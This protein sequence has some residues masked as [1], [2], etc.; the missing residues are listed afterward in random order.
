MKKNLAA[1]AFLITVL[2]LF[3][4]MLLTIP[5]SA[6]EKD[7]IVYAVINGEVRISGSSPTLSGE[8]VIPEQI[9]GYPVTSIGPSA[10][11]GRGELTGVT[12][13]STLKK[14][15]QNAFADCSKLRY[16]VIPDGVTEMGSEVFLNCV[17]L[18]TAPFPSG[19]KELPMR[20]FAGCESLE[21][22]EIPSHVTKIGMS[23]FFNCTAL[24]EVSVPLSVTEIGY[25]AFD[26]CTALE[27]V[28]LPFVG[29]RAAVTSYSS[30][31]G[32]LFAGNNTRVPSSLKEVRVLGGSELAAEAFADCGGI[33]RVFLPASLTKIGERAFRGCSALRVIE[34]D[35]ANATYH[36]EGNCLI[37]TASKKL[38]VGCAASVIPSDGSVRTIAAYAFAEQTSLR[39][40]TVPNAVQRIELNAFAGCSGLEEIS[41]PFIGES[42]TGT[43]RTN[44]G[45]IFGASGPSG[46]N[47]VTIPPSLKRVVV[48]GSCSIDVNAFMGCRD[49][50]ELVAAEGSV[51]STVKEFAFQ[52]CPS[53]CTVR[54]DG[55]LGSIVGSAF[56]ECGAL[57]EVTFSKNV[58]K[59]DKKAF[60]GCPLMKIVCVKGSVAE[61]FA[62]QQGIP[63]RLVEGETETEPTTEPVTEP[64]TEPATEPTTEPITGAAT[65]PATEF[66]SLQQTDR[67]T[68]TDGETDRQG[69][70]GG[71]ASGL[72][73][74]AMLPCLLL[75]ILSCAAAIR[76]CRR[77]SC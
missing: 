8:V 38:I 44:F 2:T 9:D 60:Y 74:A 10:F 34:V 56:V 6:D 24:R 41:L 36:S 30:N 32:C 49:L 31:L 47:Q 61:E 64:V 39:S 14:I 17:L 27:R 37:A 19:V 25:G 71:C 66:E 57:G 65:E 62:R 51:I 5:S 7:G 59:I 46:Q 12:L 35:A 40:I 13:P 43:S 70:S 21:R 68:E 15:E 16:A 45:S 52:N 67:E 75:A 69:A 54:F 55:K 33:E 20:L 11:R 29:E 4:A 42:A 48:T 26:G 58:T 28:T 72:E 1:V 3:C 76:P 22:V 63:Y 23:V 50:V 73:S 53:L 77:E 18:E